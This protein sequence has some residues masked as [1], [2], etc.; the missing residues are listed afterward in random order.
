ME[1]AADR[2]RDRDAAR[3]ALLGRIETQDYDVLVVH[4]PEASQAAQAL[5]RSLAERGVYARLE[6][7][8]TP[9][10]RWFPELVERQWPRVRGVLLLVGPGD[11]VPLA[12]PAESVA[13]AGPAE[14]AAQARPAESAAQ[15]GPAE[16]VAQARP[17]ESVAQARPAESVPQA[18]P[19][20][21]GNR[22]DEALHAFKQQCLDAR[23]IFVAVPLSGTVL[24][25]RL[26]SGPGWPP[27]RTFDPAREDSDSLDHLVR[28]LSDDVVFL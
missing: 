28:Y 22:T 16:S 5:G 8:S 13:Q 21:V 1:R 14:S 27:A 18:G 9:V 4:R 19:A 15:A 7:L 2:Q 17:A 3:V 10:D 12:G 11:S 20:D 25:S 6:A 26:H 23:K 24:P